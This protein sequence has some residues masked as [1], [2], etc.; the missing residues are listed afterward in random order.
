MDSYQL[1][2]I[3]CVLAAGQEHVLNL[4]TECVKS[5]VRSDMKSAL[6]ALVD[7]IERWDVNGSNEEALGSR[8]E[9]VLENEQVKDLNKL[10][11][12]LAEI[13]K[14]YDCIGGIIG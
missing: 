5:E 12:S 14:F 6:Y 9:V 4:G 1:F 8:N 13:D 11:K 2:L 10:L 7:M 3:K